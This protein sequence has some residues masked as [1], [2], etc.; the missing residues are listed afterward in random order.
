MKFVAF[1]TNLSGFINYRVYFKYLYVG[2]FS[3]RGNM[4]LLLNFESWRI[5][6]LCKERLDF[7][8][9]EIQRY[10]PLFHLWNERFRLV[11]YNIM[12]SI[13]CININTL[14]SVR[15]RNEWTYGTLQNT[16]L[17]SIQWQMWGHWN[18]SPGTILCRIT[19]NDAKETN[20]DRHI[21]HNS[22]NL[23]QFYKI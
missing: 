3:L 17:P 15:F 20:T 18:C 22:E 12:A 19:G 16:F 23:V 21:G 1:N 6:I 4:V 9:A 14:V 2:N 11:K 13:N 5:S 7:N 10:C 8:T